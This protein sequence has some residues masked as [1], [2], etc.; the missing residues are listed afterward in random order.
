MNLK[1]L[2]NMMQAILLLAILASLLSGG[3][4]SVQAASG[5]LTRI[6]VDASGVEGNDMSRFA[7]ISTDGRY[8][9]FE[10]DASNLISGDTNN[11]SDIF[12][13]DRVTGQ[14]VRV[15]V[16]STGVEANNSSS[17]TAISAD[18][19]FVAFS[20]DATNLVANDTNNTTDIF[21][22][23]LQLGITTRISVSSTGEQANNF[24]DTDIAISANGRF[25][26]FQS[27]ASNLVSDDGN[28]VTDIFVHDTQTG[29]TE[30]ISRTSD[31]AVANGTSFD[32]KISADGNIVA[33]TSRANNLDGNDT[34]GKTDVFV[35]TRSNGQTLRVSLSSNGNQ[36]FFDAREPSITG[37]GRYVSFSTASTNLIS[38]DTYGYTHVYIRDLQT[39]TTTLASRYSDGNVLVANTENSSFSADGRYIAFEFDD[40]GDGLPLRWIYVRDLLLGQTVSATPR[41]DELGSPS[42]PAI[43]NNAILVFHARASAF[44][45]GDTNGTFDVFAKE[46]SF[47]IDSPPTVSSIQPLCGVVCSPSALSI[48]YSVTFSESVTGVTTD[49]FVLTTTGTIA[50]ASI[51]EVV[52]SGNSYTVNVNTGIGD[53]TIRLDVVDNDSVIDSTSNPLGGSGAGNGNFNTGDVYVIDKTLPTVTSIIRADSNPTENAQVNFNVT[54]SEPVTGVDGSD[55]AISTI[56]SISGSNISAVNGSANLYIVTVNTGTGDGVLRIDLIDDDSIVDVNANVLGG[57]GAGNGNFTAGESYTID[58][59]APTVMSITRVDVNP[60]NA[61]TIRFVVTFSEAIQNVDATDFVLNTTGVTGASLN[62]I[63]HVDNIYTIT[64]NTGTG[65]GTIRLDVID[66]DSIIDSANR[67]L[68]GGGIGNGN[69]VTG[70]IYTINKITITLVTESF[71]STGMND[72]WVLEATENSNTGGSKNSSADIFKLGDDKQ[73]RQYRA[74]LHFPTYY[75]PDNAV[76][77][78]VILTIKKRDVIGTDPFTTHQNIVIDIQNG[79]FGNFNLFSFLSLELV[80]FIAP[81]SAYNVGTIQNNPAGDWYWSM[82]DSTAFSSINLTGITQI[83]LGFLL[84][85]NNDSDEDAIRFYSGDYIGQRERPHLQI[86]YYLP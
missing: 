33:F 48:S 32:P 40:K 81:A 66:D 68:G 19:R 70:E 76:V 11:T 80:D 75:L 18:G 1:F 86:E 42:S 26:A 46:L 84:D 6:S 59:T 29:M 21:L 12:V 65:N 60:S 61:N 58:R 63:S 51:I 78:R 15:S 22:R 7:S 37:D 8:A 13:K 45:S 71:R 38:E 53:G 47:Q 36:G 17:G 9:A 50:G 28:A 62:E 34:N 52:G 41:P 43:S 49:D 56:G 72:G 44:V 25:V 35:R 20:S 16:D 67:P 23:D 24:S 54:F 2:K 39:N 73:N 5:D 74:I 82:L 10:S 85:D 77:T 83:R 57:A 79:M 55:F 3:V 4:V 30:L 64:V 27:D 69:F 31:G 14:V